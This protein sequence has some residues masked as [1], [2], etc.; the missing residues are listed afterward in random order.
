MQCGFRIVEM[1]MD[2]QFEP[3][4]GALAEMK[5]TMN[6]CSEAEHIGDINRL[7]CMVKERACGIHAPTHQEITWTDGN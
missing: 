2:G 7:N 4:Q 6:V 3:L 5:I 1:Q